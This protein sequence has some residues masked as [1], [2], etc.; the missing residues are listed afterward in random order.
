TRTARHEPPG[1]AHA[2]RPLLGDVLFTLERRAV[3]A[4][5]LQR[6]AP[7]TSE[8]DR[9]QPARSPEIQRTALSLSRH[10]ALLPGRCLCPGHCG[11][12]GAC[13]PRSGDRLRAWTEADDRRRR[14]LWLHREYLLL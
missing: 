6:A 10:W 5:V 4:S 12:A 8:R 9:G 1:R 3:L 7:G 11:S 2:R 13:E 14:H